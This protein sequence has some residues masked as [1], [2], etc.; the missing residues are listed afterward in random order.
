MQ[1]KPKLD[2]LGI[3][4][5]AVG[6]G[7]KRFALKFK[8]ALEWEGPI[9]LDTEC[10]TFKALQLAKLTIW[11]A[12]KRFFSREARNYYKQL[13]KVYTSAD[14]EGDGT[15]TGG[16]FVLGPGVGRPLRFSFRENENDTDVFADNEAILKAAGWTKEHKE[17]EQAKEKEQ[18]QVKEKEK[19]KDKEKETGK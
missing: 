5:I 13:S 9:Y 3:P 11:Q 2:H 17:K 10:N 14:L 15:Q 1:I 8:T 19:E 4:L 18:E 16:V 7:S 12:I 6:N